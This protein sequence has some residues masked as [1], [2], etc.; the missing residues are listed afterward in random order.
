MFTEEF[1]QAKIQRCQVHVARNA[2]AKV[3]RKRKQEVADNL[4]DIS[5]AEKR[6]TSKA[7]YRAFREQYE[8]EIPSEVNCL[9]ASIDRCQTFYSL[10]EEEWIS[11]R[12]INAIGRVNKEFRR[13]TKPIE[14]LAGERSAYVNAVLRRPEDGTGLEVDAV[15]EREPPCP[16]EIYTRLV[17]RVRQLRSDIDKGKTFVAA[18]VMEFLRDWVTGHIRQCDKLYTTFLANKDVDRFL[19]ERE[20]KTAP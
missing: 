2:L 8:G 1:L 16:Q 13:R 14:I 5:Y 15:S 6:V 11:L 3:P 20:K 10:P 9:A 12:T 4:Q 18:D 19:A 17:A 7:A